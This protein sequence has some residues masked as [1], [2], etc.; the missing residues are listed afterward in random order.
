MAV[1]AGVVGYGTVVGRVAS[2][3]VEIGDEALHCYVL[4]SVVSIDNRKFTRAVA[5]VKRF[6]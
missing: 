1:A 4:L 6:N 5:D 3:G 2:R